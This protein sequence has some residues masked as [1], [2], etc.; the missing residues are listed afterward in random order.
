MQANAWQWCAEWY[1]E[2]YYA[3]SPVIDSSV[4]TTGS[5]RVNRGGSWGNDGGFCQS[6]FRSFFEPGLRFYFLGL[7]VARVPAD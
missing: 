4:L 5:G 7:R 1:G 6:A 3:K 2:D